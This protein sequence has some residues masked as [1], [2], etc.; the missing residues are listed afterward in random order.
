MDTQLRI[1]SYNLRAVD[2]AKDELGVTLAVSNNFLDYMPQTRRSV[3]SAY[4]MKVLEGK[5]LHYDA[6]YP[7]PDGSHH[8]YH[9]RMFPI[10]NGKT[11]SMD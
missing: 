9:V 2:F 3:L 6:D 4:M 8:Y 7:Q 1:I 11:R 10:S 5:P